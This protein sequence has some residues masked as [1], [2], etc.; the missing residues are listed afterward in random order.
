MKENIEEK[1]KI[2]IIEWRILVYV[3]FP[4][5]S[6]ESM[7]QT[8]PGEKRAEKFSQLNKDT[9]PK[10]WDTPYSQAG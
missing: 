3:R 9:D 2:C 6:W 5:G 1:V 10:A 8:L 4:E 7:R